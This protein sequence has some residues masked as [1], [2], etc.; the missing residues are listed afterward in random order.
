M[1]LCEECIPHYDVDRV[2][3]LVAVREHGECIGCHT[4][5]ECLSFPKR[6]GKSPNHRDK[7]YG[8]TIDRKD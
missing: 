2:W 1:N 7:P 5:K 4:H 3:I 6:A 8:V